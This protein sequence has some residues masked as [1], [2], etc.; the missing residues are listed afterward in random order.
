MTTTEKNFAVPV[1][2]VTFHHNKNVTLSVASEAITSALNTVTLAGERLALFGTTA[3]NGDYYIVVSGTHPRTNLAICRA[4]GLLRRETTETQQDNYRI[5]SPVD[6]H[7]RE[8]MS[9]K[10]LR[11]YSADR[12]SKSV[13]AATERR[14]ERMRR[15]VASYEEEVRSMERSIVTR[16]R[17]CSALRQQISAMES[18]DSTRARLRALREFEK[19]YELPDVAAAYMDSDDRLRILTHPISIEFHGI[20]YDM[21]C[22][23]VVIYS[24]GTVRIDGD[25]PR[26]RH[27]HPHINEEGYPCLGDFGEMLRSAV[28]EFDFLTAAIVITQFLRSYTYQDCYV[29]I[30]RWGNSFD[31]SIDYEQMDRDIAEGRRDMGDY[32]Y[33]EDE[34]E[35]DEEEW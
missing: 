20:T 35:E 6:E 11:D 2:V 28:G 21:G 23:D 10:V 13:G 26:G 16:L 14:I 31:P 5:I 32:N 30:Q 19:I 33:Y 8:K 12:F 27:I 7:A 1:N 3:I 22:Y 24:D 17:E 34:E 4:L 18:V 29:F 15:S 9:R 25:N